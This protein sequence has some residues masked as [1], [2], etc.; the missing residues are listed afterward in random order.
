MVNSVATRATV[1]MAIAETAAS[2]VDAG[3]LK[4]TFGLRSAGNYGGVV[5]FG[6][7]VTGAMCFDTCHTIPGF[8]DFTTWHVSHQVAPIYLP[9]ESCHPNNH[10]TTGPPSAPEATYGLAEACSPCHALSSIVPVHTAAAV[11]QCS[12]C[13][14]AAGTLSGRVLDS[15]GP[16]SGALVTVEGM[17]SVSTYADG[18]YAV[19]GVPAGACTVTYAKDGYTSETLAGIGITYGYTTSRDVT[20]AETPPPVPTLATALSLSAPSVSSYGSARLTGRLADASGKLTVSDRSVVLEYS[21]DNSAWTY[22]ATVLTSKRDALGGWYFEYLA[23]PTTRTYYRA[24]FS[25]DAVFAGSTSGVRAVLPKVR[26]TRST[27]W[28]ILYRYK[29]YYGAG[30]IEP[31]HSSVDGRVVIR[32][33]KKAADGRYYYKKSFTAYYSYYS[34]MKTRYRAPVRFGQYDRGTWR[35]VARHAA[36]STNALTDGIAD[37]LT[38]R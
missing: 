21:R 7:L 14:P 28:T 35:L 22:L 31:K 24:S 23:R 8:T 18:S 4:V 12:T 37:Y 2:P 34:S 30:L 17:P 20:L 3:R 9:C 11:S 38:V 19:Q 15:K 16:L 13:H 1:S 36:D 29:T 26:L 32:A 6:G 5:F 10:T 25:G 33:Y 27:E